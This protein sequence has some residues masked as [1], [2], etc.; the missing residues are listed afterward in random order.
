MAETLGEQVTSAKAN[1]NTL[2]V[3]CGPK[4]NMVGLRSA[5]KHDYVVT[6]NSILA[7]RAAA[8]AS[9]ILSGA[10]SSGHVLVPLREGPDFTIYRG[11]QHG[12][13]SPI[14][15]VALTREQPSPQSLRRLERVLTRRRTIPLG[16]SG[17]WLSL[18]TKGELSSPLYITLIPFVYVI[19]NVVHSPHPGKLVVLSCICL[20]LPFA[21]TVAWLALKYWDEPVR[22]RLTHRYGIGRVST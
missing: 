16:Q 20:V 19:S 2:Y 18:V 3:V 6:W 15:V 14:L 7:R 12:N 21:I 9:G 1:A 11:R 4:S 5:I 10:E 17:L 22:A 8:G 13:P